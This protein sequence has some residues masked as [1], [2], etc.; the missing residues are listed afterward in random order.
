MIET[1]RLGALWLSWGIVS[2]PA[3][4]HTTPA[5][6]TPTVTHTTR[7]W[8]PNRPYGEKEYTLCDK[9]GFQLRMRD[10][11]PDWTGAMVH[12]ECVDARPI[13]KRVRSR[14]GNVQLG[15]RHRT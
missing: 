15:W 7:S 9:C 6:T 1:M 14:V 11:K 5:P 12:P 10:A 4:A 3:D 13:T 8:R 2:F